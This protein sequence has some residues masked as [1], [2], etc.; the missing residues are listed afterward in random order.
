MGTS[1]LGKF[2]CQA[3]LSREEQSCLQRRLSSDRGSEEQGSWEVDG[4]RL[5]RMGSKIGKSSSDLCRFSSQSFCNMPTT[6]GTLFSLL[7]QKT[8]RIE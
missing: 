1:L 6:L 3:K 5:Y 8:F 2:L 7:F 4:R